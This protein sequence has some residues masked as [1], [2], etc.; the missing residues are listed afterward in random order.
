MPTRRDFLKLAALSGAAAG[1]S[2]CGTS[3]SGLFP[4]T[5]KGFSQSPILRKFISPL[6][7]LGATGIPLASADTKSVPGVDLY[8]LSAVQYQQLMHPDLPNPTTLWGYM[9][10]ASG[11]NAYL[12]PIIAA[13]RDRPVMIRMKNT[14][15]NKHTLP[16]DTSLM[17]CDNGAA[18]NRMTVHLH[19]AHV[20]WTSDGGPFS[21]FTPSATG[22]SAGAGECF[23]NGIAGTPGVAQYYY[24]NDQSARL[25]WYHDHALGITRLNAYAGL[26]SAYLLTDDVVDGLVSAG[27]VPDLTHTIPLVIQDKSFK[28]VRDQFGNP[29]DLW[30]PS[31]YQINSDTS[32]TGRWDQD[33]PS[34]GFSNLGQPVTPSCVPE[35][36]SDT[37]VINGEA[38][39]FLQVE[40]R[41]YRVLVLNGSQARFYNLN[42]FYENPFQPGEPDFSRGGP[43]F[44]QIGNEAGLLP[45]PVVL[46][47]PPVLIPTAADDSCDPAGPHNLLVAP[48]ERADLIIDFSGCQPGDRLILYSDAPAPFPGGDTRNDYFTGNPNQTTEGGAPTTQPGFG[49]NTRTLMQIRVVPVSGAPDSLNFASTLNALNSTTNGLNQAY[50]NSHIPFGE[51]DLDPNAPGVLFENKTLNE[52]FD[53]FGRLIQRLGNDQQIYANTF[54]HNYDDAVTE[55]YH[56]GQTVVWDVYNTTGDTHPIHFHLTNVQVIG[57]APFT[58]VGTPD[59]AFVPPEPNYSGWKE[60]VR[61]NPGEVTRVIMKFSLPKDLP[62]SVPG[63]PRAGLL[64]GHEYVW[65]C[66]ILEHEEHDMMRPLVIIP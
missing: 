12:G 55:V 58:N 29:G 30:Y 18:Q 47:S 25:M 16:V 20:P 62:F 63:S 40:P 46:N 65:H 53:G 61:M 21:W 22:P 39:P 59:T 64:S 33:E 11:K 9:D 42:L 49:A 56:D 8:N 51:P 31:V 15:P 24:P 4:P 1:L 45:A 32:Q 41:R 34:A 5:P 36:F 52:D 6:P 26:A 14:L 19:G 3:S 7:G 66:H 37:P 35:F 38:Y 54:A 27:I 60:T 57:R 50:K 17:G 28:R 13:R 43:A 10:Q 2:S 23:L 48:A 44:I